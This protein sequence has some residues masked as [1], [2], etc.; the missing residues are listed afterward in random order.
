M[1]KPRHRPNSS[2]NSRQIQKPRPNRAS[3]LVLRPSKDRP[4]PGE[5]EGDQVDLTDLTFRQQAALPAIAAASSLARASR[6]AGIDQTTL[7]RWLR[8]PR[9]ADCLA[10]FRQQSAII[11]REELH[12]LARRGLAVFA[13]AMA[14][15]D[16]AIRVRA[17]RYALSYTV[18]LTE[19]QNLGSGLHEMLQLLS[20]AKL[21][22][23]VGK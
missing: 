4:S 18:Q 16:P 7:R 10:A 8:E 14:D 21:D 9:F 5:G 11:A 19:L 13:E 22:E 6:D 3:T 23:N 20:Q 1:P 15:P 17:A 12:A 2:R